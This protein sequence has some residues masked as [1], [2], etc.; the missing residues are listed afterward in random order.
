LHLK[1]VTVL[2]YPDNQGALAGSG[3]LMVGGPGMFFARTYFQVLK[4]FK[5]GIRDD[6]SG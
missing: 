6:F 4:R 3:G 2:T 5:V 1:Q